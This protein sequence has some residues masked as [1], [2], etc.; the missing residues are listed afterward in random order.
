M[1]RNNMIILSLAIMF[2]GLIVSMVMLFVEKYEWICFIGVIV[3][4]AGIFLL[5]KSVSKFQYQPHQN[6]KMLKLLQNS[7]GKEDYSSMQKIFDEYKLDGLKAYQG[8]ILKI[9]YN[10]SYTSRLV[11]CCWHYN[12]VKVFRD[13]FKLYDEDDRVLMCDY[14]CWISD[15]Y[16]SYYG[17]MDIA[18]NDL[19]TELPAY[20]NEYPVSDLKINLNTTYL[21]KIKWSDFKK[22][23]IDIPFGSKKI[24]D[25]KI[26]GNDK[27]LKMC[28]YVTYWTDYCQSNAY[29]YC[30]E[31]DIPKI[32]D[33]TQFYVLKNNDVIAK[34]RVVSIST[35]YFDY[36]K[37][38][39]LEPIEN[40]DVSEQ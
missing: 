28:V 17:G 31:N 6:E 32:P 24:F 21:T 39:G 16:N 5:A 1:K 14:G 18:L 38:N 33:N 10:P 2:L 40:N 30:V 7:L 20:P 34:G 12:G 3:E 26:D 27:I 9:L 11:F 36:E 13:N 19:K 37:E 35:P 4:F 29:I 23:N 22:T 15:S 8:S 25:V